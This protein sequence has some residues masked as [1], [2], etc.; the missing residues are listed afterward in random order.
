MTVSV[1]IPTHSRPD[2]L[3]DCLHALALNTR[4][5][6][7]EVIVKAGGTFAENCNAGAREAEGDILVFLNDDTIVQPGWLE[8]LVEPIPARAGITGAQLFYP[9]GRIQHAGIYFSVDD[10]LLMGHNIT[11]EEP[12]GQRDAVTGACL[13]IHAPLFHALEGFDE[14]FVN[15]NEDVDLCLRARQL[16]V[17]IVYVA[18]SHVIHLESQSGPE[19]WAHVRENVMRLQE[20]WS[21]GTSD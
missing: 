14:L 18:E 20:L 9:D 6:E 19:R 5:D 13:A 8:T 2:L 1:V 10:G 15:G 12:T 17:A 21:V 16:G 4:K 3:A 11:W 7:I